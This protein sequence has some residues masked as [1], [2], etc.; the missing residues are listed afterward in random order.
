MVT[1]LCEIYF[2]VGSANMAGKIKVTI[3]Y[4]NSIGLDLVNVLSFTRPAGGIG[5]YF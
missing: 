1:N 3:Q 4:T 2:K 5:G